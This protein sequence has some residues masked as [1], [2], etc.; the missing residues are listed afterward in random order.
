V[1]IEDDKPLDRPELGFLLLVP[2][3]WGEVPL[4]VTRDELEHDDENMI[5]L[6]LLRAR[7]RKFRSKSP[8]AVFQRPSPS[9][10]GPVP[11][12][13]AM[14]LS[15]FASKLARF[16]GARSSTRCSTRREIIR[17]G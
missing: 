14:V 7:R 12:W 9:K 6:A 2:D 5:S 4:T 11:T 8:I 15:C 16:T 17:S 1:R 13:K 10:N 3:A